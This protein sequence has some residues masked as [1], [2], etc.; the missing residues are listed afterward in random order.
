MTRPNLASELCIGRQQ[1]GSYERG[2][3]KD[4]KLRVYLEAA[5]ILDVS[6]D[7]LFQ[8]IFRSGSDTG[9]LAKSILNDLPLPEQEYAIRFLKVLADVDE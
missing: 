5:F 6:P 8:D 7:F 1:L 4:P 9:T 3:V 2:Q